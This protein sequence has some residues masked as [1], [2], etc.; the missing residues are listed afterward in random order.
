METIQRK[1]GIHI[2]QEKGRKTIEK[3]HL[4]SKG[5]RVLIGISGGADSIALTHFLCSMKEKFCLTLIGIH[6]HHGIRAEDADKDAEFVKQFCEEREIPFFLF[7]HDILKEAKE[8]NLGIEEAGRKARYRDF[9]QVAQKYQADVIAVAHNRNDQAET[10]LMHLCRGAGMKGLSAIPYQREKII[11][12]LLDCTR[13]EIEQYCKEQKLDFRMDKTNF[14]DC[15]ARNKVR[16]HLIPWMQKEM[17]VNCVRHI[18]EAAQILQEEGSFL[19]AIAEESFQE[20]IVKKEEKNLILDGNRLKN[21]SP[22]IQRRMIRKA[23]FYLKKDRKDIS[24]SHI[25]SVL[26]LMENQTGKKVSLPGGIQA[27]QGYQG[28]LFFLEE[29]NRKEKIEFS[30]LL[31]MDETIFIKEIGKSI[32]ISAN[33]NKNGLNAAGMCTKVFDYDKI[34]N[35]IRLRTRQPGDR[36]AIKGIEGRKKLKDFFIDEK[37]PKSQRDQIPLIADGTE[38][39]WIIGYRASNWYLA[40]ENTKN[41]VII[42]T[43]EDV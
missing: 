32:Q 20:S 35:N 43:W 16:N 38:I 5:S 17:N 4:L 28:I 11:R 12:P 1:E 19:D 36:I 6:I 7:H 33:E 24:Y 10:V 8:K 22:V 21:F 18:A 14:C 15:Y 34:K 23:I 25:Q 13:E 41:K 29:K 2:L 30:Y 3:Y 26:N 42:Q 9:N 37:I 27:E 40:D 31:P 39:L